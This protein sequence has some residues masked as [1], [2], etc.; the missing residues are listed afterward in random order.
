M[1]SHVNDPTA[2]IAVSRYSPASAGLTSVIVSDGLSLLVSN[3][4]PS[5][6]S[7]SIVLLFLVQ[8]NVFIPGESS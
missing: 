6:S 1:A 7:K 4:F 3:S 2:F 5:H 8:K